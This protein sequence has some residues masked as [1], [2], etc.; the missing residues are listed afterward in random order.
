MGQRLR[1]TAKQLV[2]RPTLLN[3]DRKCEFET[4]L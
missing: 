2:H 3:D 4:I 1:L